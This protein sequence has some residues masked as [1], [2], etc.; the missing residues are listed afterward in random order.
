MV[1]DTDVRHVITIEDPIE[2]EHRNRRSIFEQVEIGGDAPNFGSALRAALRRDPDAILVG[3]MRDLETMQTVVTAAET[4]HLILSTLHIGTAT[5]SIHRI[6]DVFP[7]P[8]Q[9]QIRLQ[10]ALS[11][12]AVVCQQLL[13][14]ADG[15]GRVP[16]VEILVATH[17]VRNHIRHG[18]IEQLYNELAVGSSQGMLSME[19]SLADLVARGLISPDVARARSSRPA[20]LD[21]IPGRVRFRV[22]RG[23]IQLKIKN[24]KSKIKDPSSLP[25]TDSAVSQWGVRQ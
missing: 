8:Q 5:Q 18:R 12:Q 15:R 21:R 7:A 25:I 17:A 6:V 19:R 23:P 1:N 14:R 11:L 13:P 4:G 24:Q 9:E 20:E 10:L 22:E 2:Y 16:A 3:E